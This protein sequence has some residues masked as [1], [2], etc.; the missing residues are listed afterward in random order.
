[1]HDKRGDRFGFV[2]LNYTD[3]S[4][5]NGNRRLPHDDIAE[6]FSKRKSRYFVSL[7]EALATLRSQATK[8][9][10]A[11]N[12]RVVD[13][14]EQMGGNDAPLWGQKSNFPSSRAPQRKSIRN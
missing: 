6:Y 1:M 14:S 10:L 12:A 5:I 4:Q 2:T 7:G 8:H 3:F 13:K 9:W 11:A